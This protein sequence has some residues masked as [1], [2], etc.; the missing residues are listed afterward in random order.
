M[1]PYDRTPFHTEDVISQRL[2][3]FLLAEAKDSAGQACITDH[4]SRPISTFG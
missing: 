2:T 1:R 4:E 3:P